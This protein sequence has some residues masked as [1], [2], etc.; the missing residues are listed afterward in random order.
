MTVFSKNKT[1]QFFKQKIKSLK[2][3]YNGLFISVLLFWV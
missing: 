2:I 1:H 3:I